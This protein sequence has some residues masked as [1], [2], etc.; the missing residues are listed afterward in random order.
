MS[1]IHHAICSVAFVLAYSGFAQVASVAPKGQWSV[2]PIGLVAVSRVEVSHNSPVVIRQELLNTNTIG[3]LAASTGLPT[4]ELAKLAVAP[5]PVEEELWFYN[6]RGSEKAAKL[7]G[8]KLQFYVRGRLSGHTTGFLLSTLTN[9]RPLQPTDPD[10]RALLG[11]RPELPAHLL[12]RSD[13][14]CKTNRLEE[15]YRTERYYYVD[16]EVA[17]CYDLTFS[18]D[19]KLLG[20]AEWRVDANEYDPKFQSAIREVDRVLRGELQRNGTNRASGPIRSFSEI[21][22]ERLRAVG[23]SYRSFEELN[24]GIHF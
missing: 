15:S 23:I 13:F 20:H 12:K 3:L 9:S 4:E 19:G 14:E 7:F 10:L 17:W 2:T 21:K 1:T 18:E 5:G 24:P 6:A 8:E 16:R 22:K 11:R